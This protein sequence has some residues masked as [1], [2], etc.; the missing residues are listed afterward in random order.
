MANTQ[1]RE[2]REK[3]AAD[4]QEGFVGRCGQGRKKGA[5]GCKRKREE[6]RGERKGKRESEK[7]RGKR[8][9]SQ[10]KNN[11]WESALPSASP[12]CA[13]KDPW[14]G[15]GR[16]AAKVAVPRAV[17]TQEAV[18][19]WVSA[20]ASEEKRREQVVRQLK[21]KEKKRAPRAPSLDGSSALPPQ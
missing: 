19:V 17:R 2:A 15:G 6:R 18:A 1:A 12:R 11:G 21:R 4:E 14:P 20:K 9:R 16:A 7:E 10:E 5:R 3:E 13:L 8:R